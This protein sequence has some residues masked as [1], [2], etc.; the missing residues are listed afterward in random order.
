MHGKFI[1]IHR[2]SIHFRLY[3]FFT[4]DVNKRKIMFLFF[5]VDLIFYGFVLRRGIDDVAGRQISDLLVG[6]DKIIYFVI[7]LCNFTWYYWFQGFW[8]YDTVWN[9]IYICVF[10][11]FPFV[12]Y[13]I[14][15]PNK[16]L[17][18]FMFAGTSR[19]QGD[20]QALA[21]VSSTVRRRSVIQI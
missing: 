17:S 12:F 6:N 13:F 20:L 4:K 14:C 21:R 11:Y 16:H 7:F 1:Y 10:I 19:I 5:P 9:D 18:S 15:G 8:Y 3:L 2:N